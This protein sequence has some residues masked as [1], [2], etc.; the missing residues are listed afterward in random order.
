GG[1]VRGKVI[2]DPKQTDR[3]T[4]VLDR[5]KTPLTVP[6]DRVVQVVPEPSALDGYVVRRAAAPATAQGQFDLG[7]YCEQNRLP[8]L[9]ELHYEAALKHDKAF[10]PAHEKL[11]HAL[12][13]GRWLSGDE[14]R[15]AQGLVR[16]KGK[17]ITREEKEEREKAG[18]S[19]AEQSSWVRRI[20]LWREA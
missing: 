13:K 15:E 20:R 1:Q 16:F 9:A 12:I 10:A 2:P 4:V 3:V 5:G 6:K 19:A 18:E 7:L 11:G 14:L 8:D 17:W